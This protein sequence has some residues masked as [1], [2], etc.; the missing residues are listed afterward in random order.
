MLVSLL[1]DG[2]VELVITL[3]VTVPAVTVLVDGLGEE[4]SVAKDVLVKILV[5][6]LEGGLVEE[7]DVNVEDNGLV[8]DTTV[9]LNGVVV[10]MLLLLPV[11]SVVVVINCKVVALDVACRLVSVLV[12]A[13]I[14]VDEV[15][16]VDVV[17]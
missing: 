7:A 4:D 8:T 10:P 17:D 11:A 14:V 12:A 5:S 13:V 2:I 9:V 6:V 3:S 1:D 16:E 15:M